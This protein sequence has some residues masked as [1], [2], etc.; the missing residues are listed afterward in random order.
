[1]A[2]KPIIIKINAD[3][4]AG[5]AKIAAFTASLNAQMKTARLALWD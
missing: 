5:Q 3:T 4:K 1:M 2:A